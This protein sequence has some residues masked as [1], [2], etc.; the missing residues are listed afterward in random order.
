MMVVQILQILKLMLVE[1]YTLTILKRLQQLE[2]G[3]GMMEE[4]TH[5]TMSTPL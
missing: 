1:I 5:L 2:R 4:D 3:D